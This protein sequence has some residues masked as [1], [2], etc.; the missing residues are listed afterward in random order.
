MIKKS[1]SIPIEYRVMRV[2]GVLMQ[3]CSLTAEDSSILPSAEEL[4]FVRNSPKISSS[5][6]FALVGFML[7]AI[8]LLVFMLSLLRRVCSNWIH[9]ASYHQNR[10]HWQLQI[11]NTEHAPS[12]APVKIIN[13][14][15]PSRY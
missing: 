7:P 15:F 5:A 12:A 3:S 2:D 14:D 4:I 1:G 11:P 9:A 10:V 8:I 13:A 6:V